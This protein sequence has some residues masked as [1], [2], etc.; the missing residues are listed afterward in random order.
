MYTDEFEWWQGL[1]S[2]ELY[3]MSQ[4]KTAIISDGQW[5]FPLKNLMWHC[6]DKTGVCWCLGVYL[7][8]GH[9]MDAHHQ[10]ENTA[11]FIG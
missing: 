1:K 7:K 2:L 6:H 10:V 11:P 8:I 9:K 4:S 5:K 3:S